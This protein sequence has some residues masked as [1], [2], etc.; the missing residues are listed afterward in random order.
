VSAQ[1]GALDWAVAGGLGARTA[2]QAPAYAANWSDFNTATDVAVAYQKNALGE[3][4]LKGMAKKAAAMAMPETIFTLPDGY[5]PQ[6]D[7]QFP[8]NSNGAFAWV[9]INTAGNVI[10]QAGVA[11]AWVS[12]ANIRFDPATT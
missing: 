3:V 9:K 7:W 2:W 6:R 1:G 4:V 10:A 12:F 5:R 11:A 8:A